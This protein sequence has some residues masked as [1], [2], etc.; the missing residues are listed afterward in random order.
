MTAEQ[1]KS[2]KLSE[3]V[4]KVSKFACFYFEKII[5]CSLGVYM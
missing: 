5:L 4:Y 2:V 3:N 1:A